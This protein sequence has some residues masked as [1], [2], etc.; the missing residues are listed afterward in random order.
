[1]LF[2]N[3][4]TTMKKFII[5]LFGIICYFYQQRSYAQLDSDS[6]ALVALYDSTN[7]KNWN[8]SWILSNEVSTWSEVTLTQGSETNINP[9]G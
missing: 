8:D 9:A 4:Y 1:M 3:L 7:G 6:L 5:S 2:F